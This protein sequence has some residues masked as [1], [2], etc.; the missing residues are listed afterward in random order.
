MKA[1]SSICRWGLF[2]LIGRAVTIVFSCLMP[3]APFFKKKTRIER[4]ASWR[5]LYS[6]LDEEALKAYVTHHREN[7]KWIP[8]MIT[9][10]VI[11]LYYLGIPMGWGLLPDYV[12]NHGS[13][14][15]L[16]K[17][18]HNRTPYLLGEMFG[19]PSPRRSISI[20]PIVLILWPVE[21]RRASA[22]L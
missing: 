10:V 1:S 13:I 17:D 19:F 4:P 8:L 12:T 11:H 6:Q 21:E 22:S 7:T 9:N 2:W 15:G 20:R 3:T 16:D 14:I 18:K 5:E